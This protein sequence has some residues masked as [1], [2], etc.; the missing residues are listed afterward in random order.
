VYRCMLGFLLFFCS[1]ATPV[2]AWFDG[3][4]EIQNDYL[5]TEN[6]F[7][8]KAYQPPLS[9]QRE[10][11]KTDSGMFATVGS[12]SMERFYL[13]QQLRLNVPIQKTLG[14]AYEYL[15][16]S[17][18]RQSQPFQEASFWVGAPWNFSIIGFPAHNK[19]LGHMG[20][21]GGYGD[22]SQDFRFRLSRL[23]QYALYNEKNVVDYGHQI[24]DQYIN[25][26]VAY[27]LE[28][29]WVVP[30]QFLVSLDVSNDQESRLQVFQ[31]ALQKSHQGQSGELLAEIGD[32][33][34]SLFGLQLKQKLRRRRQISPD[35]PEADQRQQV[36]F[37]WVD[38][39]H[40]INGNQDW[41]ATLGVQQSSFTNN[42][43][44]GKRSDDFAHHLK[45]KQV[46]GKWQLHPDSPMS[47]L[48]SLQAGTIDWF[49]KQGEEPE[50][51]E[52]SIQIKAT[53][54]LLVYTQDQYRVYLNSTWDLDTFRQRQWD[55][56]N[57]MMQFQF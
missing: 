56:G 4:Y 33:K 11:A 14:I 2:T 1:W 7:D 24:E 20:Y 31:P 48:F 52:G 54:G 47:Y 35:Q 16:E 49:V 40:Q 5:D 50:E 26:P 32:P 6:F 57:L 44:Q 13:V 15:E 10:W 25:T 23:S 12:I 39:Y 17:I 37:H 30:R 8:I 28:W 18:Y 29:G 46:Y 36:D 38:V 45:S 42:R 51:Q 41:R 19:R 22:R 21:A 43:D 3:D 55:G 9:W 34:Q 53:C 27:R